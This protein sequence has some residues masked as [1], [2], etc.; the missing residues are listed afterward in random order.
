MID[1]VLEAAT[2]RWGLLAVALVALPGGR[3]FL[4][5]AAK[6]VIR[7]GITVVDRAQELAAEIKEEASDVVAEVR[8]E[9]QK[10]NGAVTE[11]QSTKA[12][13]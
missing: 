12:P 2:G 4:R 1:K 10:N 6:E 11:K 5:T 9:R 8:S 7:A 13:S 3:K